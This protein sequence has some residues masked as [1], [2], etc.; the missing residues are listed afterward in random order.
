[1]LDFDNAQSGKPLKFANMT[2]FIKNSGLVLHRQAYR[3]GRILERASLKNLANYYLNYE[4]QE[5]ER[6]SSLAEMNIKHVERCVFLRTGKKPKIGKEKRKEMI[7]R[8]SLFMAAAMADNCD[9]DHDLSPEFCK[10]TKNLGE[11][12]MTFYRTGIK[13]ITIHDSPHLAQTLIDKPKFRP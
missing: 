2:L 3:Q 8:S 13:T 7:R 9:D 5:T 11:A 6:F 12:L 1:M 10:A 4:S